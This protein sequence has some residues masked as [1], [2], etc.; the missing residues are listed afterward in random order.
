[1]TEGAYD[2]QVIPAMQSAFIEPASFSNSEED[3]MF[4]RRSFLGLSSAAVA[5][6]ACKSTMGASAQTERPQEAVH[7]PLPPAIA[8]LPSMTARVRPI[9]ND[10]RMARVEKAKSLM[11]ANKIDAIA[12]CGGT[13]TLYYA[14]AQIGGGERL[15]AVVIPAKANPFIVCPA[16]EEARARDFGQRPLRVGGGHPGM[17]GNREPLRSAHEGPQGCRH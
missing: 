11:A 6:A 5:A 12:L 15:W 17:A 1:M 13:S 14:N 4:S 7:R 3:P 16:F 8:A 10:E 9:T 2:P